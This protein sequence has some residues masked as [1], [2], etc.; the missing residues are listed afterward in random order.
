VYI[1]GATADPWLSTIRMPNNA[2]TIIIG[3]NQYFFLALRNSKNSLIKEIIKNKI[4][5]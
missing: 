2:R 5:L 3:S 1:N 4:L